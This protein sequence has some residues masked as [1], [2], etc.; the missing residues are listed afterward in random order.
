MSGQILYQMSNHVRK[1]VEF[2]NKAESP[3]CREQNIECL[4]LLA[5][6]IAVYIKTFDY[7]IY[8]P[9]KRSVLRNIKA[10][11]IDFLEGAGSKSR[12]DEDGKGMDQMSIYEEGRK[13]LAAEI[14]RALHL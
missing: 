13:R 12:P 7:D 5:K 14:W 10:E 6:E 9:L 11:V 4:S 1:L 2:A 8:T 3:D